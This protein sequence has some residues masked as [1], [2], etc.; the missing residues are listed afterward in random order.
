MTCRKAQELEPDNFMVEVCFGRI[1]LERG[2]VDEA[3]AAWSRFDDL[4][5]DRFSPAM[6]ERS[7]LWRDALLEHTAGK[8][9]EANNAMQQFEDKF[10]AISPTGCAEIRAWRGET[11]EAFAWL[12]KAYEAQDQYLKDLKS[13]P[14]LKSLHSDPRWNDLLIRVGLPED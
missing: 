12:E 9:T 3:R 7:R 11:D 4:V 6:F 14:E 10:A 2:L 5:R 13:I 1:L 8:T